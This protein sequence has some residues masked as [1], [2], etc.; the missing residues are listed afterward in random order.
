ME[1][2]RILNY[3]A[4]ARTPPYILQNI[5]QQYQYTQFSAYRSYEISSG[6]LFSAA[7]GRKQAIEEGTVKVLQENKAEGTSGVLT[8]DHSGLHNTT[9]SLPEVATLA[10]RAE[11]DFAEKL[12]LS[13]KEVFLKYLAMEAKQQE[14]V[15][16]VNSLGYFLYAADLSKG[17][18]S[19]ALFEPVMISARSALLGGAR[20]VESFKV[21]SSIP[22]LTEIEADD[23]G[24]RQNEAQ[25]PN[26]ESFIEGVVSIETDSGVGSGF[27]VTPGC[28]VLTN[29]HV[30]NGAETIVI[31]TS[32]KKL[33]VGH[34]L[35]HDARRDLALLTVGAHGCHY[36]K[37]GDP[38]Q[39]RVGQE[40]YAIG[41]PI[42][43]SNTVTRGIISAYRSADGVT[44]I[45]LDATINPGN[46]G[47]PLMT[48]NGD[49]IG[50]NT[51]KVSGYEG[52]NF[53]I[54]AS[55]I[56]EAFRSYIQ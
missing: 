31:K 30:V 35:E 27:F 10:Q 2:E 45:Q 15:A 55:E 22:S 32:S 50:I 3:C 40:V 21:P 14:G 1:S 16:G 17:T 9:P 38:A 28:L 48:R 5:D 7:H 6:V 33:L 23:G 13:I 41:N 54:A 37:I 8:E 26:I 34:V 49:V 46:S 24:D 4:L 42:G 18:P 47:G 39:T 52:L 19:Q 51:F 20:Q 56:K 43:L 44:Y 36:L 11:N 25:Q 53:A 29:N 12:S